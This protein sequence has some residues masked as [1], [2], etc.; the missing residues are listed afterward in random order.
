MSGGRSDSGAVDL[1][2]A[3]L[4]A[5]LPHAETM[6]FRNLDHFGIE[7]TAPQEVARVVSE[8]FRRK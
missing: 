5:V 2:A 3:R 6:V 1:V 4:P 8:F 7:R